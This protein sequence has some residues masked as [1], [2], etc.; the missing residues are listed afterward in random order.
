MHRDSW[1]NLKMA[2]DIKI[3]NSLPDNKSPKASI[4][5]EIN[6]RKAID[7][8][9]MI[10]DH[11]DIDIVFQSSKNKI[12]TFP[13]E[14]LDDQV[15]GSQNRF[16]EFLMKKGIIVPESVQGG[17]VYGSMEALILDS[18][19]QEINKEQVVFLSIAKFIEEERPYFMYEKRYEEQ[20]IDRLTDPDAEDSTELGDVPHDDNKGSIVPSRHRRYIPGYY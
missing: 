20:E 15:Y 2:I 16:F 1:K 18:S 13:K 8:S 19:N 6:A 7:G 3:G 12:V 14:M 17:N 5:Y 9:V 10:F 11:I 4:S